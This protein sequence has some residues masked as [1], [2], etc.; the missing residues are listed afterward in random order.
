LL[1]NDPHWMMSSCPSL[2]TV[3]KTKFLSK[4]QCEADHEV[5]DI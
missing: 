1:L 3:P 2:G 4:V 5:L